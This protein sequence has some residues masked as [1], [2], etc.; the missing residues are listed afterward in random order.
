MTTPSGAATPNRSLDPTRAVPADGLLHPVSVAA[1]VVL[2]ANDH[3]WKALSPGWATGKLS[4]F[5]GLAFFPLFLVGALEVLL[6]AAGKWNGPS[7]RAALLASGATAAAFVFVKSTD[8]GTS[9]W[10]LATGLGQWA[11]GT[12]LGLLIG[13]PIQPLRGT[14]VVRDSTDLIALPFVLVGLWIALR[15]IAPLDQPSTTT[16]EGC[17]MRGSGESTRS[18][19]DA[20]MPAQP[21]AMLARTPSQPARAAA[22]RAP[23]G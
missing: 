10:S 19:I 4:D 7:R 17:R 21:M 6:F 8:M 3:V 13:E 16:S 2:L 9:A 23:S 22:R 20:A 12:A 18:R 1:V 5:A 11:P 14:L 15:R